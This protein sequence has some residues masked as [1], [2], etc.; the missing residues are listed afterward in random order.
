MF[1]G[2]VINMSRQTPKGWT[3]DSQ[4]HAMAR[5]GIS[6]SYM[7]NY[8]ATGCIS[9]HTANGIMLPSDGLLDKFASLKTKVS[10]TGKKVVDFSKK[11]IEAM[12]E[13][14]AEKKATGKTGEF[15]LGIVKGEA[16]VTLDAPKKGIF[17]K[18][19]QTIDDTPDT[20]EKQEKS[21]K[22]EPFKKTKGRIDDVI[23]GIAEEKHITTPAQKQDVTIDLY[24]SIDADAIISTAENKEKLISYANDLE[25]D[26]N[27]LKTETNI[28]E[29]KF[30]EE[31]RKI[32]SKNSNDKS[33]ARSKLDQNVKMIKQ[34]GMPREQER[35]EASE[36]KRRYED[37]HRTKEN[38]FK[39]IR[40]QHR[41]D[42]SYVKELANDFKRLH[43][44]ID[45]RV[46]TMTANGIER[47]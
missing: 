44:Q 1:I 12:K 31:E 17:K 10:E 45:K 8:N 43:S 3:G 39:D 22:V 24:K 46:R 7:P 14:R 16:S 32:Q 27:I 41:V 20:I 26:I 6:T 37:E 34:S 38:L 23:T 25:H 30:R 11:K 28:L 36:L 4:R 35:F 19:T 29:R 9:N 42:I 5:Y 33:L 13:K 47:V 40:M 18:G 2:V 21:P 15:D